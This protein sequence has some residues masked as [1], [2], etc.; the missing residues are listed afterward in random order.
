MNECSCGVR[1]PDF[2]ENRA[3]VSRNF[4]LDGSI[5]SLLNYMSGDKFYNR[6]SYGRKSTHLRYRLTSHHR[7]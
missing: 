6:G 7:I 4:V 3:S 2:R 5:S 1:A